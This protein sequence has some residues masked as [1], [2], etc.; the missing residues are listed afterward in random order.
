MAM[1]S[2]ENGGSKELNPPALVKQ[3]P[4][5]MTAFESK[6]LTGISGH[7]VLQPNEQFGPKRS[8][9]I[10]EQWLTRIVSCFS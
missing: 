1:G 8:C 3:A 5:S 7:C 10:P 4:S 2:F 6:T 9:S